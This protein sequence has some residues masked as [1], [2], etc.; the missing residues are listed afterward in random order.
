MS[1]HVFD[2]SDDI[3]LTAT[4]SDP[5]TGE[6]VDP[7]TVDLTVRKPDKSTVTPTVDHISL[8]VFRA[9]VTPADDEYGRWH[10]RFHGTG[11]VQA[12]QERYFV[13]RKSEVL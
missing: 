8:G 9:T 6:L 2:T 4:F 1:R 7:D 12:A 10:Y 3:E 13:V 5:D 11:D